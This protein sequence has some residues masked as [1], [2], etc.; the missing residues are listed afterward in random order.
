[1]RK[2]DLP[3]SQAGRFSL[4]LK[5]VRKELRQRGRRANE[6]IRD[7]E[8]TMKAWL[9]GTMTAAAAAEQVPRP[10]DRGE[11]PTITELSHTPLQLKWKTDDP[12]ARYIIHCVARWHSVV[13]FSE[14][15]LIFA[16]PHPD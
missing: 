6:L 9:D 14:H 11:R 10:V 2:I 8:D 7:V 5:G 1:M 3:S 12:F 15:L 4:S 16:E 13:S